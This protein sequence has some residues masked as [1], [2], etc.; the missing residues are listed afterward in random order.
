[1]VADPAK[2]PNGMKNVADYAHSKGLK[3]GMYSCVGPLTCGGYPGSSGHEWI[4]ARTFAEWGVD[5]LKYDFCYHTASVRA[6]VL[7]HQFQMD[8]ERKPRLAGPLLSKPTPAACC[9]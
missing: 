1:M 3:F 6:A 2:F 4:D 9:A 7:R 8:R 5:F